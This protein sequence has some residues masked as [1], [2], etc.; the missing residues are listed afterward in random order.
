[1][2]TF[3]ILSAFFL[4]FSLLSCNNEN[5]TG[6]ATS[7]TSSNISIGFS[8]KNA[9]NGITRIEGILS[10][11]GY[12]T[13][14]TNFVILNDSATASFQNVTAG[15]WHLLVNAYDESNILKYTG[16]ADVEVYAGVTTPVN[17]TLN[18]ASGSINITVT[19]G[20]VG[21]E[22][23]IYNPSFEFNGQPSTA[24]WSI[25]DTNLVRVVQGAPPGEGNWSLW[26][27]P[28]Y[29]PISAGGFATTNITGQS[30]MINFTLSF[31][32]HNFSYIFSGMVI[33]TQLRKGS[34]IYSDY[35]HAD[36]T[37]WTLYTKKFQLSILPTDTLQISLRS[38]SP[39]VVASNPTITDSIKDGVLYD[40]IKLIKN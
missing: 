37:S 11:Q 5:L 34:V 10:R 38:E 17:I 12:D 8:M 15:V 32:E 9:A 14:F 19:W 4:S 21:G 18:P 28:Q 7:Q 29:G 39:I 16:S 40:G 3:I 36:T 23:L 25:L 31:W 26:I 30:G 20:A 24:D 6:V 13:L 35:I 27:A 33:I 22:N 2:K 1:M